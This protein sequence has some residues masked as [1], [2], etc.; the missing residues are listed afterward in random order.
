MT[1]AQQHR[2][3]RIAGSGGSELRQL[4]ISSVCRC[5]ASSSQAQECPAPSSLA[6]RRDI[7]A[8]L[9]TPVALAAAPLPSHAIQGLTAGRIP[10]LSNTADEDGFYQYQRPAGK[11]G[12]HG[13]GWSEI[14]RYAFKVPGGWGEV[15]VSIADLGGTEI[16]LRYSSR[17]QGEVTVVVAPVMRFAD[18]GFNAKVT[19][20]QLGTPEKII[21]GFAPELFGKPVEDEDILETEVTKKDGLS[22]YQW[23]VKPFRLVTATATGNRMFILS[24]AAS[25]RQWRKHESDLRS[26]ARSFVVPDAAQ[27]A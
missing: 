6:K 12:G 17:E 1:L 3:L 7:L 21:K 24:V 22:Y 25:S 10:G 5:T 20:E 11:S 16:D 18:I 4:R 8:L 14:P 27:S 2:S 9:A 19:I 23:A 26:I 15:P 13:V